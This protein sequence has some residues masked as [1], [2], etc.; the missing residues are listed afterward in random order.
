MAESN[1]G[2][3]VR[4]VGASGGGR[5]YRKQRPF[6]FYGVLTLIVVIGLLSVAWAR[7]EYRHPASAAT[8]STPPAVGTTWYAA[9]GISV[10]GVQQPPLAPNPAALGGFHA[11]HGGVIQVSPLSSS[12][13]GRHATLDK[14]I[15]AYKGLHVTSSELVVPMHHGTKTTLK[16]WKSGTKCAAGTPD[17]GKTGQ[18]EIA[19]WTNFDVKTATTTTDASSVKFTQSMLIS[20]VFVPSGTAPP[21]PPASARDA[22]LIASASTTTTTTVPSTISTSTTSTTTT[23]T[24]TAPTH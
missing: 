23:T 6:N 3:W 18:V 10:C 17:A 8:H 21:Q 7:Y 4:R 13:A 5:T 22:M 2:G 24:T 19:T 15:S 1:T 14:F 11:L 16:V 20:F 9:L 12:E